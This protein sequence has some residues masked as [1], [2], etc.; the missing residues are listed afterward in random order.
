M[1][2]W[3][4]ERGIFKGDEEKVGGKL[5]LKRKIWIKLR[6]SVN[7]GWK[8]EIFMETWSLGKIWIKLWKILKENLK[9]VMKNDNTGWKGEIFYRDLEIWRII[10]KLKEHFKEKFK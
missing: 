9:K 10:R 2:I 7:L 6:K 4:E 3:S 1:F 8:R 5:K